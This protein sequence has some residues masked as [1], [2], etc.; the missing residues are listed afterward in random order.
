MIRWLLKRYVP[1]PKITDAKR[2]LC[3]GAHPDDVEV[4][5][6][7]TVAR[8]TRMG[9]EVWF[10]IVTDGGAGSSNPDQSRSVLKEIRSQESAQAAAKLGVKKVIELGFPD[11]GIYDKFLV[12]QQI[13]K[14][15]VSF[16]PDLIMSPDPGLASEFHPDHIIA[17]EAVKVALLWAGYPL[18]YR[19][20]VGDIADVPASHFRSRTCAFFFTARVNQRIRFSEEDRLRQKQAIKAHQSQFSDGREREMIDRYQ[21]LR[22]IGFCNYGKGGTEGFFV[23]GGVHQHCFPEVNRY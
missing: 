22:S 7:G 10:L 11:A 5:A 17:G 20:Q 13:A 15:I 9:K 3:V 19:Q 6:G 21:R 18:A 16:D 8:L 2:I 14:V 23:L 12:A 1:L 4:G